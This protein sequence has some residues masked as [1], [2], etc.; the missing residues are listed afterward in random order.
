[1][2]RTAAPSQTDQTILEEENSR[3]QQ[4]LEQAESAEPDPEMLEL[5]S[6][7]SNLEE[8]LIKKDVAY[9]KLHDQ[10]ADLEK[11]FLALHQDE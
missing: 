3:L 4:D 5:S 7:V 1:M 6:K 11:Q 2:S 9:A 10:Y 8:E